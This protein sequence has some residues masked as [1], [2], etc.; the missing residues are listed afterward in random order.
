[1]DKTANDWCVTLQVNGA[2]NGLPFVFYFDVMIM[3][4]NCVNDH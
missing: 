4:D 3:T 2:I 1:M